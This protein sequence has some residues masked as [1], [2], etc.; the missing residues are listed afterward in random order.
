M[1]KLDRRA[2]AL[3]RLCA[4]F[5]PDDF[6]S[7]W[8]E[9]RLALNDPPA[10]VA[11]F[12][13][14]LSERGVDEPQ[15]DLA[16]LALVDGLRAR[17]RVGEI[18]W[19]EAPEDICSN[20]DLAMSH[21]P[22]EPDRWAWSERRKYAELDTLKFLHAV[23]KFLGK[24][25]LTLVSIDI[26]ADGYPLAVIPSEQSLDAQRLARRAGYHDLQVFSGKK[27][28]PKATVASAPK[29]PRATDRTAPI[30]G[31][32]DRCAVVGFADPYGVLASREKNRGAF[33]SMQEWPPQIAAPFEGFM[34]HAVR[35]RDLRWLTLF[36]RTAK[37]QRILVYPLGLGATAAELTPTPRDAFALGGFVGTRAI[38][39]PRG[40]E[41]AAKQPFLQTGNALLPAVGLPE[42]DAYD[43]PVAVV[44]LRDGGDVVIWD[45]RGFELRGDHFECTFP[46]PLLDNGQGAP[47]TSC[48]FALAGDDGFFTIGERKLHE[49]H[50]GDVSGKTH[51]G[52]WGELAT[53]APGPQQ[54]LMLVELDRRDAYATLYF[55]DDRQVIVI[56]HD[57]FPEGAGTPYYCSIT[58]RVFAVAEE[59][60]I[61]HAIPEDELLSLPR[62]EAGD[63]FD[64]TP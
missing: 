21:L 49:I 14:R 18:D 19:K 2:T 17:D 61:M 60:L 64:V 59:G 22:T 54:S 13:D 57:L 28:K 10:Y 1:I 9:V 45:R 35:A 6:R 27:L 48:T 15:D 23:G 8:A 58:R 29:L 12:S 34:R 32:L 37:E 50:R 46:A 7:L 42:I 3:K 40:G 30:P 24:R 38:V 53:V 31:P 25:E 41:R 56:P 55:P 20:V 43:G 16:W 4:L 26:G 5:S 11:Q 33:F 39:L 63:A 62:L 36:G 52:P 44:P 51:D 47:F